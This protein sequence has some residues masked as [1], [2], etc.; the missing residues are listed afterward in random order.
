MDTLHSNSSARLERSLKIS[1]STSGRCT[2]YGSQ[3]RQPRFRGAKRTGSHREVRR[4]PPVQCLPL[5]KPFVFR[6]YLHLTQRESSRRSP[7][8]WLALVSLLFWYIRFCANFTL[9]CGGRRQQTSWLIPSSDIN[10]FCR[11]FFTGLWRTFQKFTCR[12]QLSARLERTAQPRYKGAKAMPGGYMPQS[13]RKAIITQSYVLGA[14]TQRS[15]T[16]EIYN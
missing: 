16:L 11:N 12:R 13:E 6:T 1:A 9:F 3:R 2:F 7:S 4:L 14:A 10:C 8:H 5:S 15:P